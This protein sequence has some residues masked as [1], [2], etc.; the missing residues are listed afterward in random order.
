MGAIFLSLLSTYLL[1]LLGFMAK[2]SLKEKLD[3]RTLVL[4]SIYF[5]QPMLNF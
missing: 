3:E 4:V 5:L 2:A 1:I